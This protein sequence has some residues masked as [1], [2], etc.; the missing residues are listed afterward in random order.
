MPGSNAGTGRDR[1]E[2]RRSAAKKKQK[3]AREAKRQAALDE[4][5][6]LGLEE[7]FPGSD[8]VSVTQPPSSVY[9][10]SE[11]V[12]TPAGLPDRARSICA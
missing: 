5:L 2:W 6:E 4:A 12:K 10:K 3:Q 7:S 1:S 9:D 8:P 11:P